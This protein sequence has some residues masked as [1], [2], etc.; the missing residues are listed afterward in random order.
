MFV[1]LFFKS[2]YFPTDTL[3]WSPVSSTYSWAT[4]TKEWPSFVTTTSELTTETETKSIETQTETETETESSKTETTVTELFSSLT[5]ST[6]IQTDINNTT[7][8]G[9]KD[10]KIVS[11]VIGCASLLCIISASITLYLYARKKHYL[12]SPGN[13]GIDQVLTQPEST[14]P[15]FAI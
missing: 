3:P 14:E 9:N 11:L 1:M 6:E 2:N 5:F 10:S 15:D 12:L 7:S 8:N 4:P 13:E